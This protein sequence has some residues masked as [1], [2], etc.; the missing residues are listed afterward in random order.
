MRG[1]LEYIDVGGLHALVIGG[2][3]I[4]MRG[5]L[6]YSGPSKV[7][8]NPFQE[9]VRLSIFSTFELNAMSRTMLCMR[10]ILEYTDVGGFMP[11]L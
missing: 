8:H 7:E 10:G 4:F 6:E 1:I 2:L 5:I 11:W 9:A 3:N